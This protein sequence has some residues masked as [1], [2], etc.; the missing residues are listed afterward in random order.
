MSVSGACVAPVVSPGVEDVYIR[1]SE[2][3]GH[4]VAGY[5]YSADWAIY[6]G[7]PTHIAKPGWDQLWLR[8]APEHSPR[9][10]QP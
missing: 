8:A 5:V 2:R 3:L 6:P 4:H 7:T 10:P 9:P 1:A